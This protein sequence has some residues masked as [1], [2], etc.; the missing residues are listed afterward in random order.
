MDLRRNLRAAATRALQATKKQERTSTF[1][2][3]LAIALVSAP[4]LQTGEALREDVWSFMS[5]VLVP[6]L[7]YFR[8]GKTR[9]RFLGGSRNT[10]QRL[11]LR[12][13]LFDRGED[14]PDR[15]QLLDALTED[16]LFQL[17]DRPTLAGDPRL[18]RAIAEAWVTTAAATGRTRMEPIMRRAL[19]GLR[20]RREIR[21]LGQLSDDGLEKAVMGEFETAVGETAR[22]EDG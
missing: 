22:G 2:V 14:H 18:A 17:E 4:L 6:E 16:A 3:D 9:E 15:W 11:W 12:G 7:V 20:M 8:F 10:L 5:C 19:R 21:S 1:D 13:R